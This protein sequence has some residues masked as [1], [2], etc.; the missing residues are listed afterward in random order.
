M[1]ISKGCTVSYSAS[2]SSRIACG[3]CNRYLACLNQSCGLLTTIAFC[4]CFNR[5]LYG[6]TLSHIT[7]FL[8]N[9]AS[10]SF[11]SLLRLLNLLSTSGTRD[12]SIR[13]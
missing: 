10:I 8:K 12:T 9:P 2:P 11:S 4:L 3:F 7:A 5:S 6:W 1:S 13:L